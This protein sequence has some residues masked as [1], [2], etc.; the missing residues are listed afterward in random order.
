[1]RTTISDDEVHCS[2]YD[3]NGKRRAKQVASHRHQ[4][5]LCGGSKAVKLT[6]K[7]TDDQYGFMPWAQ[8]HGYTI[9][10]DAPFPHPTRIIEDI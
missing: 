3:K 4:E 7:E 8:T 5:P 9:I 6:A 10:D 1:M 2:W